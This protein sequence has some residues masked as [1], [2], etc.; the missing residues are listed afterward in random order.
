MTECE[1][2]KYI[3]KWYKPT[4]NPKERERSIQALS[5]MYVAIQEL[6]QYREIGTVEEC[7][8]AVEKQ[9]QVKPEDYDENLGY[10]VC[11]SCGCTIMADEFSDHKFCLC[12]GQALLWEENFGVIDN[13]NV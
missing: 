12:C 3:E 9:K 7:L 8:E 5:V 2:I 11:P 6:Q 10:F 13:G 1:A 4:N